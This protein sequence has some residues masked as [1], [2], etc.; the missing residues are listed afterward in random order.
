MPTNKELKQHLDKYKALYK[1]TSDANRRLQQVNADLQIHLKTALAN[2]V[3]AQKAV[4]INKT[5]LRQ[6]AEG[7][8]RKEQELIE[9]LTQLKAKLRELGY[10][11]DFDSLGK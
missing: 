10:N 5:M 4:T 2:L 6:V 11:G 7:H 8:N 3:N 9:L 1:S